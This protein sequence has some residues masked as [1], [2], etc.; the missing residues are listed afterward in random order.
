MRRVIVI[1]FF[2]V[3]LGLVGTGKVPL[4][5]MQAAGPESAAQQSA[6]VAQAL[7]P[8]PDGVSVGLCLDPTDS[9]ARAFAFSIKRSLVAAVRQH[10]P[11]APDSRALRDGAAGVSGLDLTVRLVST[12]PLAYGQPFVHVE[13]PGVP[14]LPARPD[15]TQPGAVDIGGSYDVWKGLV[16]QWGGTPTPGPATR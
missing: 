3:L 13:L 7:S 8:A 15:L 1:A 4:S 16:Q 2:A 11:A 6:P 10:L 5:Y 14:G 9:T 12:R